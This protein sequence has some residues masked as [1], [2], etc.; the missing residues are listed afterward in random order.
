ME[1]EVNIV[2][3]LE[4]LILYKKWGEKVKIKVYLQD[5]FL[6]AG[7]VGFL[8]I[9]EKAKDEFASK[10]ENYIEFDTE[11]LKKFDQYYFSYFF[12][13]YNI[14][15]KMANKLDKSF[16]VIKNNL[17]NET[18]DKKEQK[19]C[20]DKIAQE[21][22]YIKQSIKIQLDK[23][24]KIDE[25]VYN[26][27]LEEYN[28]IDKIEDIEELNTVFETIK[29]NMYE[30]HINKKLTLNLFKSILSK[31]YFGQ[32]SFLNVVKTG[33]SYEEQ[34]KVFYKDYISNIV[35]MGYI[36]DILENKY[37]IDEVQAEI[38][39]KLEGSLITKEMQSIY[40]NL[41]KK[42]IEKGKN[43]E[44]IKSYMIEKVQSNCVMCGD[45][46]LLTSTYS[47]GNFVPLAVSSDNMKNFFWN[48]NVKMPICDVCKLIL[49]CI[50]AGMSSISKTY[51][52]VELGNPVYKEKEVYSFINYDTNIQQLYNINFM[53]SANSKQDKS[54][55]NPYQK[56]IV[57]IVEQ[58]KKLTEW[59]LN[60][61]FVIEFDAEYL[62]YSRMEYFN[63]KEYVAKFF[64]KY[65]KQLLSVITDYKYKL[66]IVDYILKNKDINYLINDKIRETIVNGYEN[67]FNSFLAIQTRNTLNK[68]K[69]GD[70]K[71]EKEEIEKS[72]KKLYALYSMGV[73]IHEELKYKKELNKLEGYTYKMLNSIKAGNKNEFMDIVI[74]LNIAMGKDVSPIF[75]EV[76]QDGEL[77]FGS[78]G[79]S[80]LAGLV[81]NK[82][83]KKEGGKE[84]E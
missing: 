30:E 80:F 40:N 4:C 42:Y 39:E 22:K 27:I 15:E 23:I 32:A 79:H 69:K 81:S 29:Q 71:M 10:K 21:K 9:L 60:N 26:N 24:K 6:N 77:D 28:K 36:H 19:I 78:I 63:I 2:Q 41:L 73:A 50:P 62:A 1:W 68:L 55:E 44:D 56:V 52:E 38:R 53:L 3:A 5:W 83:E 64:T 48:Q 13:I 25:T 45:T 74:R 70:R 12:N 18:E 20:K 51:R 34:Q 66:Q 8:K 75:L 17:E 58:E 59:K 57:D 72:N 67:G 11:D 46:E 49:F 14:A 54:M 47:E 33:L 7:I 35:E 82:Y 16:K 31:T 61:I 65:S 76:M 43:I 37:T 84:N